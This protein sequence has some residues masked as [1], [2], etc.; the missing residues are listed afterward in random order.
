V[1]SAVWPP[2]ILIS[3][4]GP[5]A[6]LFSADPWSSRLY[7]FYELC[8]FGDSGAG[9]LYPIE[10]WGLIVLW[11]RRQLSMMMSASAKCRT[12]AGVEPLNVANS[13]SL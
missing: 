8:F 12:R 3:R 10:A 1:F 7:D 9:G 5:P 13:N 4:Y 11:W 2:S 6:S